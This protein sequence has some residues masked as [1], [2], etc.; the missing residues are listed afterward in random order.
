MKK[1]IIEISD[2]QY[3]KMIEHIQK[4]QKLNFDNETFSGFGIN[5]NSCELGDWIEVDMYGA[6]NLGDVNW[7][8]E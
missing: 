7:K 4:G 3:A 8:I 5:L 1:I 6:L 2:E